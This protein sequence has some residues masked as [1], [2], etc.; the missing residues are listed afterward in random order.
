M[1]LHNSMAPARALVVLKGVRS[2]LQHKVNFDPSNLEN[3]QAP[4]VDPLPCS[5][6]N[7]CD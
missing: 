1:C 5:D 6:M 3:F 7:L 2:R 4:S